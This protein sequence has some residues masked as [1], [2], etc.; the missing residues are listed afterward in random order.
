[1]LYRR[2]AVEWLLVLLAASLF[3]GWAAL[4]GW[5]R[6]L[7]NRF[8]DLAASWAAGTPDDRILIVEI[9]DRSLR[10]L[11]RWPWPR[12]VHGA[13]LERLAAARPRAIGYDVLLLEPSEDDRAVAAAMQRAGPV[14]L[15][16]LVLRDRRTD[17]VT[18]P[19]PVLDGAAA[20]IGIA[21][22]IQDEDG[23]VRTA[24]TETPVNG[25]AFPQM[26]AMLARYAQP[27][28]QLPKAQPFLLPMAH[29][30]AFRRV[31]FSSV[32]RGEVPAAFIRD[33]LVLV[34]A[35]ADGMGDIYPVPSGAGGLMAG[36]QIQA[37]LLNALLTGRTIG[38]VPAAILALFS[39]LPVW[40]LLVAFLRLRPAVNLR[41]S[42]VAIAGI[43][44]LSL[45]LVPL[46]HLWL[47]P[48]AALLGIIL[49]HML[50]G[51]RRLAAMSQFFGQ[52]AAA[53]QA[54]PGIVARP[55]RR[56]TMSDPVAHEARQLQ[57]IIGQL[58]TL[59]QFTADVVERLPDAT[60]VIDERE[61]I[62]LAN[63]GANRLFG[64]SA[65]GQ[66]LAVFVTHLCTSAIRDGNRISCPGGETLIMTDA[67]LVGGGRIVRFADM[68]DLQR[69]TDERE[70]VLQFLT[71][72]L[73]SPHAAILTLLE[74]R[75]LVDGREIAPSL[76]ERIRRHAGHGLRLAD[77]FVQLA[78]ARRRPIE[79]Q[80]VDLCDVAREAVDM[81]WPRS[82]ERA[83]R[84]DNGSDQGEIWVMG[85]HAMLLRATVNLLDNAVKF[86]PEGA[87]VDIAVVGSGDRA[88]LIVSG[89]GPEMPPG[90]AE[91]PFAL[92]AEGRDVGGR[93]SI[94]L[95]LAFVQA[96]A[97]RH[98]GTAAYHHEPGYGATF[99]IMLPRA[100]ED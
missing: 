93:V 68:T 74:T 4:G 66:T 71:H 52:Q 70:E 90:R 26:T 85:D 94:G 73:R 5:T 57:E 89:P 60:L 33:K 11:G 3:V 55:M 69:A 37:N 2:L 45:A 54:E 80:P 24:D 77:D 65:Q 30:K 67:P 78:R 40:L 75:A 56:E 49:V 82:V 84:I 25:R 43:M 23:V 20:G 22:V 50:W 48:G 27:D 98:G 12:N 88:R 39:L 6:A 47:P 13:L 29:G 59:R 34:G 9:D 61:T 51:W 42:L 19:T 32:A 97:T 87:H 62:V 41:L 16:A 99:S 15:P 44:A 100:D 86:A 91:R 92:Y 38:Q 35:T 58:R 72:D 28:L 10:D 83:I 1:M 96:T 36:V 64:G 79:P 18:R 21:E 63:A 7:D 17:E 76:V 81:V 8:Y 53:L 31:S 14:L 46:A 95:G